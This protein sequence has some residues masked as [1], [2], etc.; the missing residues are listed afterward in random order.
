MSKKDEIEKTYHDL[1]ILAKDGEEPPIR[2]S[3]EVVAGV[4]DRKDLFQ[5]SDD[6]AERLQRQLA[7]STVLLTDRS[8]LTKND[9]GI[10]D[11]DVR[12]FRHGDLPPCDGERFAEQVTGGWCSGFM[13]G[14]DL[15][16]TAG[17]CG[18][19]L[20]DIENTAY[21]FGFAVED[22]FSTG[23]QRFEAS[24]VYFGKEL[25]AHDLSQTGDYAVV[26]VDRAIEAPG[27]VALKVRDSGAPSIDDTLGV[28]GHPSGLPTKVAFGDETKLRAVQGPWLIANL[29]TYGGNSGSAVFNTIGEV[30]GILVR[31]A[32][33]YI[34]NGSCFV[35][36]FV[37]DEEGSEAVT[38]ASVFRQHIP[39]SS[40]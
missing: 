37:S 4:D 35:T 11:L 34:D 8:R 19:T 30:E 12:P 7:A 5:L 23:R 25:I 31:G 39:S 26:R 9:D 38:A 20:S 29:D 16:A 13:V 36:N 21:V 22:S 10:Y 32:Q 17:H 14:D 40:S 24:Q 18:T 2:P 6:A 15:I 33:D 28:I 27:A 1:T 3:G